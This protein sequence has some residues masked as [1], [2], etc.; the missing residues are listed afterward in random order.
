MA[1][2][3]AVAGRS[4]PPGSYEGIYSSTARNHAELLS[5]NHG[6]RFM[7]I[8]N[9]YVASLAE[10]FSIKDAGQLARMAEMGARSSSMAHDLNNLLQII[11]G[12][13]DFVAAGPLDEKAARH[14]ALAVSGSSAAPTWR[15]V[16]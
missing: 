6:A 7:I 3:I 16:P 4:S 1:G 14:L 5:S 8:E 13:L 15:A 10:A 9:E 12:N 2:T 11:V